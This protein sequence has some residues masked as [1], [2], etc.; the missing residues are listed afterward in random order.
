MDRTL[1]I[2]LQPTSEQAVLLAETTRQFTA[3]FNTVCALGYAR[4]EK[5]GVTL[6]LA[7]YKPLK[8]DYPALV[9]DH[10]IQARVKATEAVK[11]ALALAKQGRKVSARR[12]RSCPPRYNVHTFTVDWTAGSVRLSTTGGRIAV[13]FVVPAYAVPSVGAKTRTADLIH[14]DGR[15]L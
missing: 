1:R 8:G 11:S 15:W 6:H 4:G 5:N 9:S 2:V 13:P 12:S 3:V 7:T 14:R 10:H